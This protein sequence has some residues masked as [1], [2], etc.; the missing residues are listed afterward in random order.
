LSSALTTTSYAV[1]GLLG[2]KQWTSYELTQ[3]MDRSLGRIWPRAAS[4]LYE[5]P[6]KLVQHGL[7][8][9]STEQNGRRTRTVYAIT[10]KGRRALA[11]WLREPGAGPVIEF[12]QLL[13]VFFAEHG[14]KEDALN[15]LRATQEWAKARCAESR[16][17]GERY[18]SGEGPFPARLPELQLSSRFIT[19]FYLLVLDW[20]EWAAGIVQKWP[21]DP[22]QA[23][24]DPA[25]LAETVERARR[26]A[27]GS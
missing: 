26:A 13:K 6:K 24:Q 22:R 11:A 18:L 21:A 4:K 3:Q 17:V 15:T 25:A 20:A 8:R 2:I 16:A 12:E 5:E 9:A 27:D 10:P 1:L 19:D 23:R 7:A 14:T